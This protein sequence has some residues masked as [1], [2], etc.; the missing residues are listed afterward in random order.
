MSRCPRNLRIQGAVPQCPLFCTETA[1]KFEARIL[2][3]MPNDS[4]VSSRPPELY[5]SPNNMVSP[6]LSSKFLR[7]KDTT[8]GSVTSLLRSAHIFVA[9]G[10]RI[11]HKCIE[12]FEFSMFR[13]F[14]II[15]R[16]FVV[17]IR[18]TRQ[19]KKQLTRWLYYWRVARI[20]TV[21]IT[22]LID[23]E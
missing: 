19:F 13:Y 18:A 10:P 23:Y 22:Y 17:N 2:S 4:L 21:R 15:Y 7:R 16:G 9:D 5:S 6:E 12:G 1:R 8:H 11:G 3:W 14:S 20:F